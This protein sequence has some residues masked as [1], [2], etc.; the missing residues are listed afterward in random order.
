M[1]N[2]PSWLPEMINI[3]GTWEEIS[4]LLYDVF[5]RDIKSGKLRFE[6][7]HVWYDGTIEPG[8]KY[9][10]GFWHLISQDIWKMQAG[11]KIK[12][13]IFDEERARR[14]PWCAP[15]ISNSKEPDVLV[16]DY[17]ESTRRIRTYLWIKDYDYVI[18]LEKKFMRKGEIAFLVTAFHVGGDFKRRDLSEKY[19]KRLN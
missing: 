5:E 3:R 15:T 14:L 19:Q 1:N 18:I 10:E 13:R 4:T 11:R 9:E 17:K 7:R 16:W 12:E 6:G 8:D 2:Y